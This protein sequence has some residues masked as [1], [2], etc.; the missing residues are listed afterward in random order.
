MELLSALVGIYFSSDQNNYFDPGKRF[1]DLCL[2]RFYLRCR[3]G[4]DYFGGFQMQ[5]E[6][7][8]IS[9]SEFSKLTTLSSATVAR[10]LR[11]GKIPF[12]KFGDRVLIPRSY[13]A[14]LERMA[15]TKTK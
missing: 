14:E 5:E 12:T 15:E 11:D 6:S 2:T 4:K 8:F 10:R 13:L 3:L 9:P 7:R 1:F